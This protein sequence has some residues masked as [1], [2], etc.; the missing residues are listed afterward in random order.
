MR[1][2]SPLGAGGLRGAARNQRGLETANKRSSPCWRGEL[3]TAYLNI[4]PNTP[5]NTEIFPLS[6]PP[7]GA[8]GE[9]CC[10][11]LE[12]EQIGCTPAAPACSGWL[13]PAPALP[14][15]ARALQRV[16]G[17]SEQVLPLLGCCSAKCLQTPLSLQALASARE[18]GARSVL[19]HCSALPMISL[20]C[21]GYELEVFPGR[22]PLPLFAGASSQSCVK[23]ATGGERAGDVARQ[24]PTAGCFSG[25]TRHS[26][27]PWSTKGGFP[28]AAVL[29]ERC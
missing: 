20:Q 4:N 21:S 11:V 22:K 10:C 7:G 19:C 3:G 5:C 17:F 29:G 9:L 27:S 12:R 16:P 6:D 23:A 26:P 13:L 1:A 18:K 8:L 24:L 15:P 2:G 14:C 28:G 25:Q